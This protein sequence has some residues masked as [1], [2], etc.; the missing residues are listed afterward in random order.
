[1]GPSQRSKIKSDN[2]PGKKTIRKNIKKE[3]SFRTAP[4][5]Y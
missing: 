5:K 1:M 4:N 2:P 3:S